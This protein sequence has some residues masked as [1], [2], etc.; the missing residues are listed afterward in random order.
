MAYVT[1]NKTAKDTLLVEGKI[2]IPQ[3]AWAKFKKDTAKL[4]VDK[5]G[6]PTNKSLRESAE[7]I[8]KR[9]NHP[10]IFSCRQ[11]YSRIAQGIHDF[12]T[13][14]RQNRQNIVDFRML[15]T[16]WLFDNFLNKTVDIFYNDRTMRWSLTQTDRQMAFG[17]SDSQ[18]VRYALGPWEITLDENYHTVYLKMYDVEYSSYAA[19]VP[20]S[21]ALCFRALSHEVVGSHLWPFI[22]LL[23]NVKYAARTGGLIRLHYDNMPPISFGAGE[24]ALPLLRKATR[25]DGVSKSDPRFASI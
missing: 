16:F 20:D 21:C 1:F 25:R 6:K 5:V 3:A 8:I 22:E 11:I 13:A 14:D 23:A 15:S 9:M 12:F 2:Y 19:P 4:M 18:T 17:A 7:Y 10:S 24:A